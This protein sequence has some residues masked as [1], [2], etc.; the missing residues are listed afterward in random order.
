[1]VIISLD[2]YDSLKWGIDRLTSLCDEKRENIAKLHNFIL[3]QNILEYKFNSY[4]L[5]KLIN[6]KDNCAFAMSNRHA[7]LDLGISKLEM[8]VFIKKKYECEKRG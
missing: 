4:P 8:A 1:M 3:E 5:E 7:L 6:F 2:K